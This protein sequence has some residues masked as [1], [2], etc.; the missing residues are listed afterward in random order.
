[1]Q[2]SSLLILAL[3]FTERW[4]RISPDACPSDSE[5]FCVFSIFISSFLRK[6]WLRILES[7]LESVRGQ[8]AQP[9]VGKS[10]SEHFSSGEAHLGPSRMKRPQLGHPFCWSTSS[11]VFGDFAPILHG[12]WLSV[13]PT[14]LAPPHHCTTPSSADCF[15]N[16]TKRSLHFCYHSSWKPKHITCFLMTSTIPILLPPSFHGNQSQKIL[17]ARSLMTLSLPNPKSFKK[18]SYY[19]SLKSWSQSIVTVSH[20]VTTFWIFSLVVF[21]PLCSFPELLS[22]LSLPTFPQ[23]VP[24]DASLAL[25]FYLCCSLSNTFSEH[26]FFFFSFL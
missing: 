26:I 2:L 21:Q 20:W 7:Q 1:M 14:P 17:C 6:R 13:S 16:T 18:S 15:P 22:A 3:S 10:V 9:R 25:C 11:K 23:T 24:Q 19:L 4:R 12:L 8:T 5:V